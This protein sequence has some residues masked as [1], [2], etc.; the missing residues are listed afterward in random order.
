MVDPSAAIVQVEDEKYLQLEPQQRR[1]RTFEAIRALFVRISHVKTLLLVVEDLH[2]IDKTSEELLGYLTGWLANTPIMLLLLYRP[3]YTHPWGS[4]SYYTKVGLDQLGPDSSS[5]LVKAILACPNGVI[6]MSDSMRGLVEPSS[7]LAIVKSDEKKKRIEVSCL[8]RSSV[9][10]AKEILGTRMEALFTLAGAKVKISGGY[11]GW[12][13]NMDSPV[14][15]VAK[16]TYH[17]MY[18][19]YPEVKAIHA[20]LECGLL[21]ASHPQ[22]DMISFGPTIRGAHTPEEKIEIITATM[23]WDLLIDVLSNIPLK[24]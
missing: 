18:G 14:L 22:L 7:N 15:K 4:K 10:S 16:E 21:A 2:W 9:D 3:E 12:K 13:P 8:M 17:S 11:P 1:Q 20:G 5:E 19:K 23:F 6:R 24:V